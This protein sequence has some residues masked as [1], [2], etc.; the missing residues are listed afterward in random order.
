MSG[1]PTPDERFRISVI[2]TANRFRSPIFAAALA[3]ALAHAPVVVDSAAADGPGD[4]PAVAAAAR[5]CRRHHDIDLEAHRSTAVGDGLL[6]ASDVVLCFEAHHAAAAIAR[7]GAPR[8]RTLLV[9]ELIDALPPGLRADERADPPAAARA[10]V[11]AVGAG[12]YRN[13]FEPRYQ[14]EDPMAGSRWR[15]RRRIGEIVE[16][17]DAVAVRLFPPAPGPISDT[18]RI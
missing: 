10:R 16:L 9:R 4:M 5:L 3:R 6:A 11:A 15:F 1:A 7:G 13:L 8:E 14:Y 17:A 18:E 12:A 2:C